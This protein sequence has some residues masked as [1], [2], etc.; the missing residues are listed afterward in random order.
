MGDRV[1]IADTIGNIVEKNL[2]V[3]RVRTIKNVEITI[4]NS[5]VLGSHIVNFSSSAEQKGLILHTSVTIGYDAPW[6]TVHKL[7]IEAALS[8][9][10]VLREPYPFVLQTALDDFYV[11]YEINAHTDHPSLMART[12]SDLHQNIQDKFYEAGVE[13]MSPHFSSM[14]DGNQIAIPAEYREKGYSAPAFRVGIFESLNHKAVSAQ[15][16]GAPL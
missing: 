12:Y 16:E 5:M 10:H 3:T 1:K 6:R 13:I 8:T 11:H 2:L 14:R 15:K 9:E 4:A 7:L